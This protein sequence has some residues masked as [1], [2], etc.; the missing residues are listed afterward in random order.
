MS[1]LVY[2][3]P[4]LHYPQ[5]ANTKVVGKRLIQAIIKL[6]ISA[7]LMEHGHT[8][9]PHDNN[10]GLMG[11]CKSCPHVFGGFGKG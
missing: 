6:L 11:I 4:A 9:Y 3:T 5:K 2:K 7:F 1:S 10:Q 8:F